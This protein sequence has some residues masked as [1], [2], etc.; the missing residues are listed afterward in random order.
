MLP[1]AMLPGMVAVQRVWDAAFARTALQALEETRRPGR[2]HR[3][4]MA[5]PIRHGGCPWPLRSLR[6]T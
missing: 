6:R 1:E 4:A 5:M 3:G 2:G